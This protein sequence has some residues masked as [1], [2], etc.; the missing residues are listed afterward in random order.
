MRFIKLIIFITAI[1]LSMQSYAQEPDE[2][3]PDPAEGIQS[4][5][6]K[7][8]LDLHEVIQR[9]VDR[10]LDVRRAAV[11]Y[12]DAGSDLDRFQGQYDALIYGKA[13][14][15]YKQ[16][17]PEN[18]GIQ[19]EGYRYEA[20]GVETGI[21]KHF[22]TG[23]TVQAS[24]STTHQT[25]TPSP[26]AP[27]TKVKGY[28]SALSIGLSQEL[29]KN[30]FGVNERRAERSLEM[31]SEIKQRAARQAVANAVMD[32]F[33]AYWNI[34]IASENMKTA[35]IAY[36]NTRDIR[37]LIK[38]K[39]AFG[40]SEKEELFDWEGRVLQFKNML[41]GAQLGYTNSR[42]GI[43]RALDMDNTTEIELIQDLDTAPPDLTFEIAIREA[44]KNRTDLANL[45][46]AIKIAETSV[47]IAKGKSLP[48]VTANAGVGYNDYDK[49]SLSGS[50]D[51]VNRQW[52][53]G[54]TVS[55]PIGG[56]TDEADI[57]T[58]K[59]TLT[60][61][62]IELKQLERGIRDE[63]QIRIAQCETTYTI[64]KQTLQT[65]EYARSYYER[66]YNKFSQGRYETTQ[67]KLAFDNYI[68]QRNNA[69]KSLID[70]NIARL[71][72]DIAM[73]TVFEKYQIDVKN[74][75][76]SGMSK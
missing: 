33:L 67:L 72:L 68:V 34:I 9:I 43:L 11:D 44:F 48:S 2:T 18:P 17:S 3:K 73:N 31:L 6:A 76:E 39:S 14:K 58:A 50:F 12:D 13:S 49:N 35:Q 69:L 70:Y 61:R 52:V 16:L 42:L 19:R 65:S 27:D 45:R 59:N 55:K 23:T 8:R 36:N 26:L 47:D 20:E 37:N 25:I 57:R 74:V 38:R 62:Q 71:Q 4:P 29:L 15:S 5:A 41:D 1:T 54:I 56:T 66:V 21:M 22:S 60:K 32:S 46:E 40:I 10:N 63:I 7:V 53:V 30:A 64:Y 28:N 75:L 51:T 24:V